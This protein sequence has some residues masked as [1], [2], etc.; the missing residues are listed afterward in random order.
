MKELVDSVPLPQLE[1]VLDTLERRVKDTETPDQQ[2]RILNLAGDMCFDAAQPERALAY[3]DRAITIYTA[4]RQYPSAARICEKILAV[5]P[6]SVRP[7]STLAW[8][9]IKLGN[10]AEAQRRVREYVIAAEMHGLSRIA[11]QYLTTLADVTDHQEV[12]ESVA[13]GLMLLEDHVTANEI[14][15]RTR[16]N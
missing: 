2:A 13:D 5:S 4:C 3:Y 7:Y 15:G 9:A 8:L 16:S 12:L 1:L 6:E 11:K 14:L 10:Y